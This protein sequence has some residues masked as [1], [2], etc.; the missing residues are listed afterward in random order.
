MMP[1]PGARCR[2]SRRGVRLAAACLLLVALA[3]DEDADRRLNPPGGPDY[4]ANDSPDNL[5]ANVVLALGARDAEGYAALLYDGLL[6]ATDGL[7]YAP[8]KY[9]FPDDFYGFPLPD[10][11]SLAEELDCV[12]R[13]MAGEPGVD[14]QG[15]PVPGVREID[16]EFIASGV[17]A[18]VPGAEAEGDSCPEDAL[19]RA[20]SSV[21]LVILDGT[22]GANTTAF[23]INDQFL[24]HCIPVQVG[25]ETAWRLWKWREVE[26]DR[27]VPDP[28]ES[29]T[30]DAL[31]GLIK[32]LYRT[33]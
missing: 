28:P 13:L 31:W 19:W 12:G 16:V 1:C 7:L 21:M 15:D 11:L 32:L 29:R 30:E 8:F 18:V 23:S 2:V 26:P 5:M 14:F 25:G 3:C 27:A 24:V 4:L 20:Y 6:P 10:S 33:P 17:W 22:Y 9:Y